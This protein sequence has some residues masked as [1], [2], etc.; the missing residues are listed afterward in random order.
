MSAGFGPDP[1]P[2]LSR[3][4]FFGYHAKMATRTRPNTTD[5]DRAGIVLSALC[6]VHC[7][8]LPI[9][10]LSS[11]LALLSG[12][13]AHAFLA[14]M[15]LAASLSLISPWRS[16]LI[17]GWVFSMAIGGA[18]LLLTGLVFEEAER[19][20]TIPGAILLLGCHAKSLSAH[21]ARHSTQKSCC[22]CP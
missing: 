5:L 21:K 7:L 22:D 14:V 1:V 19:L 18:I 11:S 10:A 15:S 17:S 6:L 20:L 16:R 3:G 8:A 9:L 13:V 12:P 2:D 4:W